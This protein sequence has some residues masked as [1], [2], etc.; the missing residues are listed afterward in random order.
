MEAELDGLSTFRVAVGDPPS[1][2]EPSH[3][4]QGFAASRFRTLRRHDTGV[5]SLLPTIGRAW[6]SPVGDAEVCGGQ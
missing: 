4:V 5:R 3:T 1:D 6:R 2:R